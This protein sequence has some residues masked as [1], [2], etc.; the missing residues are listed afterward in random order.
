MRP[1][2]C[3]SF[4]SNRRADDAKPDE[5]GI[6]S[7]YSTLSEETASGQ[8]TSVNDRT[9]AHRSLPFGT[10]VRVDNQENGQSVV[11]V[12]DRGPFVSGR[13]MIYRKSPHMSSVSPI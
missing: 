7:V 12:T 2:C 5:C 6:A 9:A 1:R 10:L 3:N 13:I 4:C 8:D 11:R